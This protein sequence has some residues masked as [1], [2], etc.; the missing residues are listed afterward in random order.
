MLKSTTVFGLLPVLMAASMGIGLRA[1]GTSNLRTPG[2]GQASAALITAMD[3]PWQEGQFPPM[4]LLPSEGLRTPEAFFRGMDSEAL[5]EM[6]IL[7]RYGSGVYDVSA[8]FCA[9]MLTNPSDRQVLDAAVHYFRQL[10]ESPRAYFEAGS[11]QHPFDYGSLRANQAIGKDGY[12]FNIY[13]PWNVKDPLT[14]AQGNWKHWQTKTG[15]NAWVMKFLLY[16]HQYIGAYFPEE[17][18]TAD[19]A[20]AIAIQLGNV[21]VALQITEGDMAGAYRGG[22]K[23]QANTYYDEVSIENVES[24]ESSIR[25]L[26]ELTGEA[27]FGASAELARNFLD[28]KAV[29][30]PKGDKNLP[31]MLQQYTCTNGVWTAQGTD[32]SDVIA[33]YLLSSF[34]K[35]GDFS[36]LERMEQRHGEGFVAKLMENAVRNFGVFENGQLTGMSFSQ[37][38][39]KKGI[40][41]V[42]WGWFWEIALDLT[43]QYQARKG[44]A[45][46][47]A[48]R[49]CARGVAKGLEG[50]RDARGC[51]PYSSTDDPTDKTSS[52]WGWHIMPRRLPSIVGTAW[53]LVAAS[54]PETRKTP[55]QPLI[56]IGAAPH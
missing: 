28:A 39:A 18:A 49:A 37:E 40:K 36:G 8:T 13:G 15:E 44:A 53:D 6:R 47:A 19:Q 42:E 33:W 10:A 9:L 26:S 29:V 50:L 23:G 31:L 3:E 21:G 52:T 34:S 17:R 7:A 14:G 2:I 4:F 48:F 12:F 38:S 30:F 41:S 56:A 1:A 25:Y 32:A 24:M 27:R 45:N 20:L 55:F 43:A 51:S 5:Q 35:S 11:P 46:A 54:Y 22:P 16:L